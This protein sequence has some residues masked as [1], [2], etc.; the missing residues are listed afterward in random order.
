MD[1]EYNETNAPLTNDD[2]ELSELTVLDYLEVIDENQDLLV[3]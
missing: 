1:Y 2:Q 3:A